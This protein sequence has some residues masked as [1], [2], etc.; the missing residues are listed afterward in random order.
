MFNK[1]FKIA[2]LLV[3]INCYA[4][5]QKPLFTN[6]SSVAFLGNSITHSGDFHHYVSLYYATRFPN[7]KVSFYNLGIRGNNANDFLKRMDIDILAKKMDYYVVM[8]GMNDVNRLLYN[9][10]KQGDPEVQQ[11]KQWALNDYKKNYEKVIQR[12][13]AAGS[14]VIL[15]KPSIYD[16][17]GDLRAPNQPGV[18]DA[19]QKCT[20]IIDQLASKYK[21][22]IIDYFTIMK[23]INQKIQSVDPK[24]TIV[25]NDRVHPNA[26]GHFVMAY[27]FL[28]SIKS[29]TYVSA[30]ELEKGKFKKTENVTVDKLIWNNQSI[31]FTALEK[32]LP[33]PVPTEAEPALNLVPFDEELNTQL[34]KISP[35]A[36]GNYMLKIDGVITANF[37]AEQLQKGVNLATI[38]NTPQYKQ[39]QQVAQQTIAYRNA[40][41]KLRDLKFIEYSYFPKRIWGSSDI[42]VSKNVTD[43]ILKSLKGTREKKYNELLPQFEAYLKNKPQQT[44][45]EKMVAEL[46]NQIYSINKPTTHTYEIVKGSLT[47]PERSLAP[48]GTNLASAEFAHSKSPGVYGKDYTYPTVAELDY[49]AAKG[50]GLIRLPFL[51]E[52][53]QH[54]LNG[55]LDTAELGRIMS[56][57]DAARERKLYV[58]LDMHNYGRRIVN[59]KSEIIGSVNLSIEHLADTWQKIAEKFKNKDNIWAYGLMNEPHDMLKETPWLNIAQG[60]I[61]KIRVVDKKTPIMIGGDSYSSAAR[62]LTESDNLKY[63]KDPANNLIFE[64][65]IYFDRDASGS[66][67]GSYE[68]ENASPTIGIERATP[69]INWLKSNKFKGFI[70]E[71]GVPDDDVRWLVT[72]NKFLAFL[73]ANGLNGTYWAAGP[74]WGNY[75]L[76]I[77]PKDGQ[78]RPQLETL[79]RYK[80]TK[81]NQ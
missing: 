49:F 29:P 80:H 27:Q 65:H 2:A 43:S 52:R 17:T 33:F 73:K 70:G 67:K 13:L 7:E 45:V 72:L 36:T 79:M 35:L 71:Y 31:T 81:P 47:M 75:K 39:A 58:L 59:G 30:I 8:A 28:K 26:P 44:E 21:L 54:Q 10:E 6:G 22:Q 38:K 56:F 12:L 78:D 37:T 25:G 4:I 23:D 42:K 64:A 18:N 50:F 63:L 19:L 53:I 9:V 68:E 24:K 62:W 20:E 46:S 40:Q 16:Q 76:A 3:A 1:T 5:A 34:L 57:V 66:Y 55:E 51:W 41:R 15:Q 69:F 14:K 74:W 77:E 32:S 60:S 61:N 48:F 11:Q